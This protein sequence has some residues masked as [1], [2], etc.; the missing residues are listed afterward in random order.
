MALA[1]DAGALPRRA[2]SEQHPHL[3]HPGDAG[4]NQG[5]QGVRSEGLEQAR[6]EEASERAFAAAFKARGLL[7]FFLVAVF[8]IITAG[9][10]PRVR[11]PL[12]HAR[13]GRRRLAAAGL[14]GLEPRPLQLR[15]GTL[16]G[17]RRTGPAHLPHVGRDQDIAIG[18]DRVFEVLDL[19][20]EVQDAADARPLGRVERGVD[21][22]TS[23]SAISPTGRPSRA[24][25]SRPRWARS[26]RSSGRPAPARPP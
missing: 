18:L 5:H 19:E 16:R 3:A 24:W 1:E 11:S 25:T 15:E 26:R 20:P 13:G 23:T 10:S 4:R 2:R 12:A 21:I 7:A 9:R 14:H 17:R 22:A 8:W 6:F